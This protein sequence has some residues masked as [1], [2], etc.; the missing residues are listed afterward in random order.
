MSNFLSDDDQQ[1]IQFFKNLDLILKHQ[2]QILRDPTLYYFRTER[3]SVGAA[4]VGSLK[5]YLGDLISLWQN[6]AI[7]F[8]RQAE[9]TELI[10]GT[11]RGRKKLREN[12]KGLRVVNVAGSALSGSNSALAWDEAEQCLLKFVSPSVFALYATL[13][14]HMLNRPSKDLAKPLLTVDDL[15]AYLDQDKSDPNKV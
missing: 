10:D 3:W 2:P 14:T 15:L 9:I 8:N 7:W 5:V 1:D 4:P 6:Q 11:S 13:K 12:P